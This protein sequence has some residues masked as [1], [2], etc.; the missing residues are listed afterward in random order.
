MNP[1][2]ADQNEAIAIALDGM[3][4]AYNQFDVEPCRFTGIPD[5][6]SSLDFI[7]YE[8]PIA[9]GFDE[10]SIP[11]SIAWGHVLATTFGFSWVATADRTDSRLFALQ[12]EDPSVLIFPFFRLLE[13]TQSS[14]S[15]DSPAESL[16][17]DTI[18]YFD[19]RSHIPDGWHPVF[20]AVRCPRKLGCPASLTKACQRLIDVMPEFYYTMSTY[21]YCW[22]RDRKWKELRDYADQL[23]S[24]NHQLF[25]H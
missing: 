20:D 22:A 6:L 17:F 3:R 23:A 14:G 9:N 2:S 25:N 11:F 7:P 5:D 24:S 4:T 8:L 19:Q 18:R 13:I 15:Q 16:W 1:L 12:H 21:P 10:E